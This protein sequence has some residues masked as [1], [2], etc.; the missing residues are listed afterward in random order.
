MPILEQFSDD[1]G[2]VIFG[3]LDERVLYARFSRAITTELA[4]RFARRFGCIVGDVDAVRYFCD[5]SG[6]EAYDVSAFTIAFDALLGKRDQFQLITMLPWRTR[7][8]SSARTIPPG[9]AAICR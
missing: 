7:T 1:Y 9:R 5:Y 4:R 2:S 8:R 6:L 3:W